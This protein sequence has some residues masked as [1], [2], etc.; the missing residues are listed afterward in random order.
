M[1]KR[2]GAF[3]NADTSVPVRMNGYHRVYESFLMI[4]TSR[5]GFMRLV[6][7]DHLMRTGPGG[8]VDSWRH[9]AL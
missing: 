8:Q 1:W 4:T 9:L 5:A 7:R 6:S 2:C 3:R